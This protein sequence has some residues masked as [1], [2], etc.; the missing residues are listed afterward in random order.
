MQEVQ[1]QNA[2][3][4]K[5]SSRALVQCSA[6]V[7]CALDLCAAPSLEGFPAKPFT[8]LRPPQYCRQNC[9]FLGIKNG[10]HFFAIAS[11][12][13]VSCTD[14]LAASVARYMDQSPPICCAPLCFAACIATNASGA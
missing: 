1:Y 5:T 7:G 3:S 4:M 10:I 6:S 8:N 13:C 12:T 14:Y 2:C 9:L 11:A